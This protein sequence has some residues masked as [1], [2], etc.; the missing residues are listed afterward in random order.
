[1]RPK[2]FLTTFKGQFT[3]DELGDVAAM[4]T[5]YAV[6]ALFPMVVFVLTLALLIV[7]ESTI[8][9]GLDMATRAMPAQ[10]AQILAEHVRGLHAAAGG[11]MAIVGAALALWAAS[12]GTVSLARALN[13]VFGVEET[14][15]WWKLNLLAVGVTLGVAVLMIVALALLTLGPAVGRWIADQLGLGAVFD[16]VYSVG[17]WLVAA[18]LIMVVWSVLYTVLPNRKVRMKLLSTGG[19]AGVAV[20]VVASLGFALYVQNFGKYEKTYGALGAVIVFL[21]WLWI[22]NLA[23][24]AGAETNDILGRHRGRSRAVPRVEERGPG[25]YQPRP[26]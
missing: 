21:I 11:F 6:L 26:A 25:S 4:M 18:F 12:R 8:Q 2:A 19:V 22:S 23:L 16:A 10:A 3:R 5:Y 13:R 14:R 24:L 20:W 1:M 17:R 7:P 15:P 9:Q